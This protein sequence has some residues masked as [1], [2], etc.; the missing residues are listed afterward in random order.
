M[1]DLHFDPYQFANHGAFP[2]SA[3]TNISFA[4]YGRMQTIQRLGNHPSVP[5]FAL[6]DKQLQKVLLLR[7]WRYLHQGSMPAT[8]DRDKINRAAT[9][10]ALRGNRCLSNLAAPAIQREMVKKHRE[11]VRRAGSWLALYSSIAY[12]SWRLGMNSVE[13]AESLGITPYSVRVILWRLRDSAKQLGFPVGRAGHTASM[14]L[15][16]E[17]K[18]RA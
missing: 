15:K 16:K 7:A 6:N 2:A 10:K 12:R 9:A 3:D 11:A 18:R 14:K 5:P 1:N 8:V 13:V 17:R 4:D